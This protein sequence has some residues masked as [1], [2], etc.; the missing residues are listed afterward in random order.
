MDAHKPVQ[1]SG[2]IARHAADF[3]S[4]ES[5]RTSLITVTRA[6]LSPDLKKATIYFTVLPQTEEGRA[7]AF[8][9]RQRNDFRIYLRRHTRLGMLPQIDFEIDLGEKNRQRIDD[10]TRT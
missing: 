9:Q 5:S 4:R 10:L 6:E 8:V 2:E 3:L 1:I 7:L